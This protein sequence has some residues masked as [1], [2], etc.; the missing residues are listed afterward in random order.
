[1]N[2]LA[3]DI[4]VAPNLATVWGIF[5]Q[6]IGINQ[7]LETSYIL[8]YSARWL[9]EGEDRIIYDSVE[10]TDKKK[11]LTK[12]HNLLSKADAVVH[13]NGSNFDMPMINRE[14][15]LNGFPPPR[16]YKNIDLLQVVRKKFRFV[17]NKL[18]HVARELG[19]GTKVE[20]GGHELWL[21]CM[22]G[23]KAAWA[24][25][26]EYNKQDVHL[27][28]DLYKHILPWIDNHPNHA[29][30]NHLDDTMVCPNCGG[31]HLVK[32]GMAHMKTQSYQRYHCSECGTWSRGRYTALSKEKSRSI[33]TQ[34]TTL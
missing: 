8:C 19:I 16:P 1:M 6:N 5:K 21:D 18:D 10:K 33:L 4:E 20:T 13:Y 11:M 9:D 12:L 14:F 26:E 29:L 17:S 7:L 31:I 27:L 30:D 3:L 15:L 23:D 34:V 2:I 22:N 24:K 25:M 28:V 32:R